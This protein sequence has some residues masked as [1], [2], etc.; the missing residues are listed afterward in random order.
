MQKNNSFYLLIFLS[1]L[2]GFLVLHGCFVMYT[3][4]GFEDGIK[5]KKSVKTDIE[6]NNLDEKEEKVI[7]KQQSGGNNKKKQN[8]VKK[9]KVKTF[10]F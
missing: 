4:E 2:F 7:P 9:I 3:E 5:S 6:E 10:P 8:S 1:L